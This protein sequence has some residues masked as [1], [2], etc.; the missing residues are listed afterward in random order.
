[1]N[2]LEGVLFAATGEGYVR[3]A[4]RAAQSVRAACPGLAI[5]L[6]TDRPVEMPIFDRIEIFAEP[7]HRA[8]IDALAMTR[9]ERTLHLD[10]DTFVVADIR[11]VFEVLERFDMA[12][13][14]DSFR[15]GD[16]AQTIWRDPLPNAFPHFNGGVIVYRRNERV[17]D[18]LKAWSRIV[19]DNGLKLDQPV[20]RELIWQSD[21]RVAT[22][23]Y[24]YNIMDYS[25]I[26][27]MST[28][29]AAPRIIHSPRF[30]Q[31]FT[32]DTGLRAVDTLD[33]LLGPYAASKLPLLLAADRGLARMAGREPRL[34]TRGDIWKRR[35][36]LMWALPLRRLRKLW[37]V[38]L[39]RHLTTAAGAPC[40][41]SGLSAR[42][43]RIAWKRR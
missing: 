36:W 24:E 30:H 11:D 37:R 5:D 6:F 33:D 12:L 22:L 7:W 25:K 42:S 3:L 34:I 39:S 10:A 40:E 19:R 4:E 21:L 13:A 8:R 38:L 1:M 23:P 2:D 27:Y 28:I 20:L 41:G 31:H 15:N 9:F 35:L 14:H 43:R 26:R 32:T 18:L 16:T 29:H 17:I